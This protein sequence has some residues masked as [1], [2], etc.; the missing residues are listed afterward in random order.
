MVAALHDLHTLH[1]PV[2]RGH[3]SECCSCTSIDFKLTFECG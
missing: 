1:L 2:S 3:Y